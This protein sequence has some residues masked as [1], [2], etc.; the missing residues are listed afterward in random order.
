MSAVCRQGR[1]VPNSLDS[2]RLGRSGEGEEGEV[3]LW[4]FGFGQSRECVF[5]ILGVL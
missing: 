4:A 1:G 5:E 3:G 2:F